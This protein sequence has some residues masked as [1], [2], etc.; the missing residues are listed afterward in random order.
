M[1]AAHTFLRAVRTLLFVPGD[2][3]DRFAR[4]L[5]AGAGGVILD[6]ED[7]VGPSRKDGARQTVLAWLAQRDAGTCVGVR[8]NA[9]DTLA[10][11]DDLA[12]FART[13]ETPQAPD[14]Y[15]LS[16]LEAPATVQLYASHLSPAGTPQFVC[17]IETALGLEAAAAIAAA[18]PAVAMLG[19]GGGD[20]ARDLGADGQWEP[21][22]HAR[23]RIVQAAASARVGALDMPWIQLDDEAGLVEQTRRVRA[24]GFRSKIA[25]HPRQVPFL[26]RELAP[27]A[28]ALAAARLVVQ[29][30][31]S[32]QGA[33]CTVNGHLVDAANYG[34]ALRLLGQAAPL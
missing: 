21:L 31:R 12:A 4:S 3:P 30:Y 32:A 7:A 1:M 8:L 34:A 14:F 5:A 2:R 16:K 25:I 29:A 24:L 26:E 9:I 27:T 15:V 19:F 17:G 28:E 18:S 33:A 10:G 11:L 6:L 22:L 23:S 13:R 20:L